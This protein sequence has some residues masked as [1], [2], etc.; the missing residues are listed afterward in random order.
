MSSFPGTLYNYANISDFP[1]CGI[2][3][4]GVSTSLLCTKIKQDLCSTTRYS[5]TCVHTLIA[6]AHG[7]NLELMATLAANEAPVG[8]IR[9]IWSGQAWHWGHHSTKGSSL[10]LCYTASYRYKAGGWTWIW[11]HRLLITAFITS[12]LS[13]TCFMHADIAEAHLPLRRSSHVILRIAVN[14]KM[15]YIL[16]QK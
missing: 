15:N 9:S 16:S 8:N 10:F 4:F 7:R 3:A 13:Y 2:V 12:L 5:S 11:N 14:L 1:L 6:V